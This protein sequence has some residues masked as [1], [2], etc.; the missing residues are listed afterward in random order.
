MAFLFFFQVDIKKV[1]AGAEPPVNPEVGSTR[2]AWSV[3]LWYY[4]P[5]G[6]RCP[7]R[8]RGSTSSFL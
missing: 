6:G 5:S 3:F 1:E 2:T 7:V 8:L 4:F